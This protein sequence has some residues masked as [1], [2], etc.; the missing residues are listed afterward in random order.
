MSSYKIALFGAPDETTQRLITE[1]LRRGH[2][3]TAIVPDEKEFVLRHPHLKVVNGDVSKK[4]DVKKY[5]AGHHAVICA[6][7]PD[8][9]N[10][11]KYVDI[12]RSLIEGVK[13]S[14][15]CNL[16]S[17]AH[18]FEHADEKTAKEYDEFKPVVKAQQEA[19]KLLREEKELQWGYAHSP[20]LQEEKAGKFHTGNEILYTHPDGQTRIPVKEYAATLIDEAENG[21]MEL[22]HQGETEEREY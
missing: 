3:V 2:N 20:E 13:S 12:T 7:H 5:A 15:V 18:P 21:G 1:S 4:E 8:H 16:I 22:Y 11:N 10:F 6:H 19:L 17:V 9:T 14:G